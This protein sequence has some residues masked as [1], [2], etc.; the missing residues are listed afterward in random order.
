MNDFL[1]KPIDMQQLDY[2]L[3]KWI[4]EEKQ[5]PVDKRPAEPQTVDAEPAPARELDIPGID[6]RWGIKNTGGGIEIYRDILRCFCVDAEEKGPQ[7]KKSKEE[8]DIRLYGIYVHAIKGAA[9][10]IGA[11]E[12]GD[13]AMRMEEAALNGNTEVIDEKTDELL[14]DLQGMTDRIHAA[15]DHDAG[16]PESGANAD[17]RAEEPDLRLDVLKASLIDMDIETV[18][19]LLRKYTSMKLDPETKEAVSEIEQHVLMFEYEK[20]IEKIDV[21]LRQNSAI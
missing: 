8:G 10:S 11:S 13:F 7:I 18:N 16:L 9:R 5:I 20:V 17:E 19:D 12:L 1:S 14:Y 4:P 21:F 3:R 2:I 6:T 15:L